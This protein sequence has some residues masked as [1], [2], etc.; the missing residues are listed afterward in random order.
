MQRKDLIRTDLARVAIIDLSAGEESPWH[1]HSAV[2][3]NV[4]CLGGTIELQYGEEGAR[5]VLSP[6]E[7]HE[8]PRGVRHNLVNPGDGPSAYLL[9][10][11][12]RYDFVP[13]SG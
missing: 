11:E 13:T 8:I 12:G 5:V 6:G 2:T 4:V 1:F 3:E 7:R 10:Q 9:V